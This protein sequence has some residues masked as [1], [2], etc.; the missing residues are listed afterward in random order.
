[1]N[2]SGLLP[3][4][5]DEI[6]AEAEKHFQ[7]WPANY[8]SALWEYLTS[9]FLLWKFEHGDRSPQSGLLLGS[10]VD[11]ETAEPYQCAGIGISNNIDLAFKLWTE[12]YPPFIKAIET[13][14]TPKVFAMLLLHETNETANFRS[15]TSAR[16]L[17][18]DYEKLA[19]QFEKEKLQV[20]LDLSSEDIARG[21]KILG[22]ARKGHEAVHGSTELAANLFRAT[23]TEEKLRRDSIRG[24]KQA[25]QTHF[26]V[27]AKVRQ[28]IKD[29]G[30]TMPEALPTPGKSIQQIE[31][32]QK[33]LKK[34]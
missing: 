9:V 4:Q 25:N 30:G 16:D 32:E 29:L 22:G 33:K 26:E 13:A 10:P 6:K 14:T 28:T 23:Q 15:V 34:E 3:Y 1:M 24:K 17:L 8:K 7:N 11:F 12:K 5:V 2:W 21:R 31:R 19:V 20:I 18:H 27:G